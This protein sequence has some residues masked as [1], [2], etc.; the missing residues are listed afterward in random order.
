M[1]APKKANRRAARIFYSPILHKKAQCI[2][3]NFGKD[4]LVDG[5]IELEASANTFATHRNTH[6]TSDTASSGSILTRKFEHAS[7]TIRVTSTKREGATHIMVAARLC[8][9]QPRN[10]WPIAK[11]VMTLQTA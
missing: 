10:G 7:N 4:N 3:E 2:V 8:K 5:V 9:H 1:H 11:I 6:G